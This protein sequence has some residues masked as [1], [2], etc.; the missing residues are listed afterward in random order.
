MSSEFEKA[1]NKKWA[2]DP[3]VDRTEAEIIWNAAIRSR[4]QRK[5]TATKKK[6]KV[7]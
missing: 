2:G 4:K 5:L 3:Y 6:R 1:Y 7:K